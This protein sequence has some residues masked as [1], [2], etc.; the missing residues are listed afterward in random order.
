[1]ARSLTQSLQRN[2]RAAGRCIECGGRCHRR[3]PWRHSHYAGGSR[4]RALEIL[5]IV[6]NTLS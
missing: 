1:L 5:E 3:R 2:A 4:L 6:S